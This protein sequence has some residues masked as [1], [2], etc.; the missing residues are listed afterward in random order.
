MCRDGEVR[1]REEF[2]VPSFLV[3][4]ENF[5]RAE[6]CVSGEW[7]SICDSGWTTED[8]QVVCAQ[9]GQPSAGEQFVN[10]S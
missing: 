3:P 10:P 5:G 2:F 9:L 8:A 4:I 6:Y 7:T 1:L